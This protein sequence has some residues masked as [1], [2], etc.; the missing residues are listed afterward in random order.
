MAYTCGVIRYF[1]ALRKWLPID[2]RAAFRSD[3]CISF[4]I[5]NIFSPLISPSLLRF[6]TRSTTPSIS[7]RRSPTLFS[8][9]RETPSPTEACS[10][11]PFPVDP[12]LTSS[13]PWWTLRGFTGTSGKSSFRTSVLCPWIT[14]TATM[15]PAPR[16]SWTTCQSKGSKST[17]LTPRS[18][19]NRLAQTLLPRP[20]RERKTRRRMRPLI[21]PMTMRSSSSRLLAEPMLLDT[22]PLTSSSSVWVLMA[23]LAPCSLAMSFCP[24]TTGGSRRFRTAPSLP[25]EELPLPIPS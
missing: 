8:K 20:S 22:L 5:I 14:P 12:F 11:S 6:S 10:L 4:S 21:S 7:N 2:H 18:S 23:T 1:G 13:D 3:N 19:G 16:H 15:P 24:R 9:H 25:R 17:L